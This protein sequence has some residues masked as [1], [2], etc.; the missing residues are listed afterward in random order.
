MTIIG[1]QNVYIKDIIFCG[2]G[3]TNFKLRQ[4]FST[5]TILLLTSACLPGLFFIFFYFSYILLL[6]VS[7]DFPIIDVNGMFIRRRCYVILIPDNFRC[8]C[9][10]NFLVH[11]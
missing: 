9:K 1:T 3:E 5:I 4:L 2:Y 6:I 7:C 11:L 8:I 10:M